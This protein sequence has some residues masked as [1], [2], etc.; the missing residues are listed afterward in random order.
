MTVGECPTFPARYS[1]RKML[2]VQLT[3]STKTLAIPI[4]D[5][6]AGLIDPN[7]IISPDFR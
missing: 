1:R 5:R 4:T 7:P 6:R 2:S 3:A